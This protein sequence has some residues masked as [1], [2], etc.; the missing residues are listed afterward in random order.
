MIL[1]LKLHLKIALHYKK[2]TNTTIKCPSDYSNT[3]GKIH[4]NI[5]Y[6]NM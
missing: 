4:R 6:M 2:S 3:Y 1:C 5:N